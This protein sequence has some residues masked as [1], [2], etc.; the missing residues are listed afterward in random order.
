MSTHRRVYRFRMGPNEDQRHALL[1]NAG[2]RRWVWN[3]ALARRK[4][5]YAE[6]GR[7]IPPSQLSGEL[8]ALKKQPDTA[9]LRQAHAQALQQALADLDKAFVA[10]FERRASFPRF[11][12]KKRCRPSFRIPQRV[13]VANGKVF[14]PKIG[15]VTI[16]QSQEVEG[17]T[18]GATFKQDALGNW[19][20]CLVVAFTMP[21]VALPP[22]DPEKV[23]GLDAGLKDFLAF[24][25]GEKVPAPKFYRKAEKALRRAQRAVARRKA[26]GRRRGKAKRRVARIQQRTADRRRDF[27]HKL[28]TDIVK[29]F[30]GVCIEDLN[31]RGLARAK[32]AKSFADASH[33]EFRRML[34]YK[35]VW[36][37]KH[38]VAV[39]RFFPSS[40]RCNSCGA[41]N[42][43]LTLADRRWTC[44]ACGA[45]HDRDHNAACNVKEE[46]LRLLAAGLADS[47]NARGD[48]VRPPARG[49]G[50]RRTGNPPALA[51][52]EC[53]TG[54]MSKKKH[55]R[56]LGRKMVRV[57]DELH[58]LLLALAART[59]RTVTEEVAIAV[60]EHLRREGLWPPG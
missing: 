6:H 21:D 33:G 56:H 52:G 19:Y 38:L 4:E 24:S 26:G 3:W 32:L 15:H 47:R 8:T 31:V 12:S 46:G 34:Q 54:N 18:K 60:E 25:T 20:V 11:K 1:C 59:R 57:R 7:G 37:R 58:S 45:E 42:D 2:A 5:Y 9:W 22:P 44:P 43:N 50:R 28:S 49:G 23:V 40:K 39:G 41:V 17:E 10:F 36:H 53:Q 27:L 14:V 55:D 48:G 30:D 13:R 51:A 35:C 29:R 16:R